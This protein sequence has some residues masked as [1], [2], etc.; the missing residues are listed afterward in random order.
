[1]FKSVF[2][3]KEVYHLQINS[4]PYRVAIWGR[5]HTITEYVYDVEAQN[6]NTGVVITETHCGSKDE[7]RKRIASRLGIAPETLTPTK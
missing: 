5:Y 2:V 7:A 6:R 1:M 3:Q 4:E